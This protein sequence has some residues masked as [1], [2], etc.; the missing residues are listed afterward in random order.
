MEVLY[1]LNSPHVLYSDRNISCGDWDDD[2]GYA[3]LDDDFEK[4][5]SSRCRKPQDH[6]FKKKILFNSYYRECSICGYSPDL[7][8]NK[9]NFLDTHKEF[10]ESEVKKHKI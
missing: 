2:F 1:Y 3:N 5:N 8:G 6:K 4:W 10:L 7:D 9:S